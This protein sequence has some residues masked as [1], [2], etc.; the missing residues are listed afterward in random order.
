MPSAGAG[1]GKRFHRQQVGDCGIGD[2]KIQLGSVGHGF[3][4]SAA[5][6][7]PDGLRGMKSLAS[8][9]A[10]GTSGLGTAHVFGAAAVRCRSS[11]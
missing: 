6:R 9:G 11:R 4:H 5:A 1:P 7:Y 10:A 8:A 2:R 3:P